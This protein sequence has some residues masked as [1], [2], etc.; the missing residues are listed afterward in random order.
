MSH[1]NF[2]RAFREFGVVVRPSLRCARFFWPVSSPRRAPR[3]RLVV[4]PL[5]LLLLAL[6]QGTFKKLYKMRTLKFGTLVGEDALGNRYYENTVDYPHGQHR[7]IEYADVPSKSGALT[8]SFYEVDA[9]SVPAEWH[10]WLHSTTKDPPTAVRRWLAVTAGRG[11]LAR[12]SAT[13]NLSFFLSRA[14]PPSFYPAALDGQH[15]PN[16]AAGEQCGKQRALH[17]QPGRRHRRAHAQCDI[18]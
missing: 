13:S 2:I 9:S 15:R 4:G 3:R 17:T 5:Y 12:A 14:L 10:L 8:K 1:G 16:A 18:D 11:R 6:P 7:W